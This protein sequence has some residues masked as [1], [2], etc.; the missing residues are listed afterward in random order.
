MLELL[1][2][3][4]KLLN[5]ETSRSDLLILLRSMS[6]AIKDARKREKHLRKRVKK[7]QSKTKLQE[8]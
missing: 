3:S 8:Q 6:A 1:A 2:K 4:E 5:I 7:L